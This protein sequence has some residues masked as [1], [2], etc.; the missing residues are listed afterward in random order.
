MIAAYVNGFHGTSNYSP[1][2]PLSFFYDAAGL[3]THHHVDVVII[4]PDPVQG[5]RHDPIAA[6]GADIPVRRRSTG[7]VGFSPCR[8]TSG[9]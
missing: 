4:A 8:Q 2:S 9:A 1:L 5:V 6:S 3:E 7:D